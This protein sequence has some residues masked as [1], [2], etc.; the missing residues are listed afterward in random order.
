MHHK[1]AHHLP[2]A[3][4]AHADAWRGRTLFVASGAADG[5]VGVSG[6]RSMNPA[7]C[8]GLRAHRIDRTGDDIDRT[9]IAAVRTTL[10]GRSAR[11]LP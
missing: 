7:D 5:A 8:I 2:P 11:R 1:H 9:A 10:V 3:S 6:L 4:A